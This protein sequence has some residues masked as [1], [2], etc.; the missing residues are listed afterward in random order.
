MFKKNILYLIV[1][2]GLSSCLEN[3]RSK[4]FDEKIEVNTENVPLN[5]KQN[6]FPISKFTDSTTNKK[7]AI[8]NI[9]YCS[10]ILFGLN[11]PLLFNK[12]SI[13]ESFRLLWLRSFDNPISIRI[14]KNRSHVHI[15]WK[16]S[17]PSDG[18]NPSYM[19]LYKDKELTLNEWNQFTSLLAPI[20]YWNTSVL[21]TISSLDGSV[22]YLEGV[23][24]NH[25]HIMYRKGT[26]NLNSPFQNACNYLIKL[27]DLNIPKDSFY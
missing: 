24:S 17:Y 23:N 12:K 19:I 8:Q 22:W 11:E 18:Y 1:I 4:Y 16:E 14:E 2:I 26:S 25:Y 6:Y 3:T 13:N 21:D 20:D 9:K 7:H 15:T 27:T 5:K 10:E